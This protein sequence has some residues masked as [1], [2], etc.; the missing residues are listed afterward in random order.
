MSRISSRP[1]PWFIQ[2]MCWRGFMP[3]GTPVSKTSAGSLPM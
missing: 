1:P 2:A 3:N